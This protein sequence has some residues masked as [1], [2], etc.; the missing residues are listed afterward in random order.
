MPVPERLVAIT[1]A[2]TLV[3]VSSSAW[4]RVRVCVHFASNR[5]EAGDVR[6]FVMTEIDRHPTHQ[7]VEQDCES[8]VTVELVQLGGDVGGERY[9]TGRL[10]GEVPHREPV[11]ATG[12]AKAVERLVTVIL[13]N[14][15]RKLYGPERDDWI[16]RTRAAFL[17]RGTTHFGL[18]LG[19]TLAFVGGELEMLPGAAVSARREIDRFHIGVRVGGAVALNEQRP[20][21]RLSH[22]FLAQIELALFSSADATTAWFGALVGGLEYQRYEGVIASAPE[23]R[24]ESAAMMGFSIGARTGVEILRASNLRFQFFCQFLAPTFPAR[25]EDRTL[26]NQWTPT[27]TLGIAAWL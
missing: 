7:A 21:L 22:Q 5:A 27:G 13:H 1:L 23:R 16:G 24:V 10:D 4:A 3:L 26:V 15:P 2:A 11:T 12:V 19:Q 8:H 25:D 20:V 9:V 17:Q 14:D 18:E 6:R